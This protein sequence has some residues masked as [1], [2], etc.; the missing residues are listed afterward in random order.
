MG[1]LSKNQIKES[2]PEEEE[3]AVRKGFPHSELNRAA[4]TSSIHSLNRQVVTPPVPFSPEG[5]GGAV[6]GPARFLRPA[7][8]AGPCALPIRALST[9]RAKPVI[10]SVVTKLLTL[11]C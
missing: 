2:N 10:C 8:T 5:G 6:S 7:D 4:E 11:N 9:G 1:F 3:S